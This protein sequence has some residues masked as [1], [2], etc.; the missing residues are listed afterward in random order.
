MKKTWI[1]ALLAVLLVL[2]GCA[3][4]SMGKG[5]MRFSVGDTAKGIETIPMDTASYNINGTGPDNETFHIP[6]VA[7]DALAGQS[8]V[9][10]AGSWSVIVEALNEKGDIIGKGTNTCVVPVNG[11]VTCRVTV[12]EIGGIGTLNINIESTS[13]NANLSAKILKVDGTQV[14]TAI[15]LNRTDNFHSAQVSLE[16][17]FYE[18]QIYNGETFIEGVAARIVA[19]QATTLRATFHG[20]DNGSGFLEID[21]T[22]APT[23]GI[24][25]TMPVIEV[26]QNGTLT[27]SAT[28]SGL[29]ESTNATFEWYVNGNKVGDDKDLDLSMSTYQPGS[30]KLVVKVSV[31][32]HN[33]IWTEGEL[34]TVLQPVTMPTAVT[35]DL[36]KTGENR[37][38]H[39]STL[40][41][42]I[43]SDV[44]GYDVTWL[45]DGSSVATDSTSLSQSLSDMDIGRHTLSVKLEKSGAS[46]TYELGSFIVE[47]DV[48]VMFNGSPHYEGYPIAGTVTITP[49]V[50]S[51]Y[52][53]TMNF[54]PTNGESTIT[55]T[56]HP[57]A[58]GSFS[59]SNHGLATGSYNYYCQLTVGETVYTSPTNSGL[60]IA[61][62]PQYSINAVSQ[63]GQGEA[64]HFSVAN[65]NEAASVKWYLDGT[66]IWVP[67]SAVN[68]CSWD[69]EALSWNIGSHTLYADVDG[70]VTPT[71]TIT[72]A[73]GKPQFSM[74]SSQQK[75]TLA[76]GDKIRFGV[77]Q[78]NKYASVN[79]TVKW[80]KDGVLYE[81]TMQDEFIDFIIPGSASIGSQYEFGCKVYGQGSSEQLYESSQTV[82]VE[83]PYVKEESSLKISKGI[84]TA[85]DEIKVEIDGYTVPSDYVPYLRINFGEE[86]P[87]TIEGQTF[88]IDKSLLNNGRNRVELVVKDAGEWLVRTMGTSFLYAPDGYLPLE[89]GDVYQR[90]IYRANSAL[91]GEAAYSLAG[92]YTLVLSPENQFALYEMSIADRFNQ[93]E[94]YWDG[95]RMST[96]AG[97]YVITGNAL[98]LN[99]AEGGRV[100]EYTISGNTLTK[101]NVVYTK[102]NT[103]PSSTGY[104]GYW[105]M[106]EL[107]PDTDVLNTLLD[108]YLN[109]NP[110][111]PEQ[112][113][114]FTK[115]IS[116]DAGQSVGANVQVRLDE[117]MM[118]AYAKADLDA[119]MLD[120]KFSFADN[121]QPRVKFSSPYIISNDNILNVSGFGLPVK[122]QLSG[123]GSVMLV[124]YAFSNSGEIKSIVVPLVRV[125]SS[126]FE[127]ADK[128][129]NHLATPLKASMADVLDFVTKVGNSLADDE[130]LYSFVDFK[131]NDTSL[132]GE[133]TATTI[134]PSLQSYFGTS[135]RGIGGMFMTEVDGQM[136]TYSPDTDPYYQYDRGDFFSYQLRVGFDIV[137]ATRTGDNLEL[138]V[139]VK[140]TGYPLT[141]ETL[142][143]TRQNI[144]FVE[145]VNGIVASQAGKDSMAD[146]G[147]SL[148]LKANGEVWMDVAEENFG[149]E[150]HLKVGK[151]SLGTD[152][153]T[154]F[155]DPEISYTNID[156][157]VVSIG[158]T[159]GFKNN[160]LLLLE[161]SVG[162]FGIKFSP[163]N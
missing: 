77:M 82:S 43:T 118:T 145:F 162:E 46:Q 11:S 56:I 138:K 122:M 152:T 97:T 31:P 116:F 132:G 114:G 1:I 150:L 78:N 105:E 124:H 159:L 29:D 110:N 50:E 86:M 91:E 157:M 9:L 163:A 106:A 48:T 72:V 93:E 148:T 160:E 38:R 100:Q 103:S 127:E 87:L 62:A 25:I 23:P 30:Y 26:V 76:A 75:P 65:A 40:D 84:F 15:E 153:L 131:H 149:D 68:K 13:Q 39:D 6:N 119:N 98:T 117:G 94:G 70:V 7:P 20:E 67:S 64:Y 73:A 140:R 53:V 121:L 113:A 35:S 32:T 55:R 3:M 125:A 161:D 120:G 34:F 137:N 101:E 136:V 109:E 96:S 5:E 59:L 17:G 156:D 4:D 37:H 44:G 51:Y 49:S 134:P 83:E 16:N 14:G 41:V 2:S 144:P 69:I 95:T 146:L 139:Q 19:E 45:F 104:N 90:I 128:G 85:E 111:M 92:M 142:V 61:A 18:I 89:V 74:E 79:Y 52:S 108:R 54:I 12:D 135:I 141:T 123:D 129:N 71:V 66:A 8:Q 28:V 147:W 102:L 143:L 27:A 80:F 115:L 112:L 107:R 60:I 130:L 126:A 58:T 33:I 24:T 21:N 99:Y 57:D 158:A 88:T 42:T 22:I 10:I 47:P 81:T 154:F 151:Y 155:V 63:C 133:W 36:P